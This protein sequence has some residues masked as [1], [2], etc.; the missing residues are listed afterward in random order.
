[1]LRGYMSKNM[2]AEEFIKVVVKALSCEF[3]KEVEL[4]SISYDEFKIILD[5]CVVLINKK[6]INKFKNPYGS[7]RFI[8]EAFEAQGFIM[9]TCSKIW[10]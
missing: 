6:I 5:D 10:N 9:E 2:K 3:E 7:D 8:L 4:E 1:M